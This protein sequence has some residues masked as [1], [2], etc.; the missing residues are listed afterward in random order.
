MKKKYFITAL[1]IINLHFSNTQAQLNKAIYSVSLGNKKIENSYINDFF[2]TAQ[3]N[4]KY[5]NFQLNF[6]KESSDFYIVD[7]LEVEYQSFRMVKG[8]SGYQGF[9]SIRKNNCYIEKEI[10]AK[11]FILKS[12]FNPAW[13]LTT[14]TKKI[15]NYNCYK[16]TGI[17]TTKING[18]ERKTAIVAWYCPEISYPFGP[19]GFGRLPG[20]IIE[21]QQDNITYGL[22]SLVLNDKKNKLTE[23]NYSKIIT[24]EKYNEILKK[25]RKSIVEE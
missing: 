8:F 12:N 10:D 2:K 16:A 23:I 14:E 6:S 13:T 5:V 24:Q 19:N 9:T 7:N 22:K 4:A 3:E 25:L 15:G 1:I 17:K 18:K 21:L 20:L 11:T